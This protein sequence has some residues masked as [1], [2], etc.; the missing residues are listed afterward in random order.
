[1]DATRELYIVIAA[2][3]ENGYSVDCID[4]WEGAQAEDIHTLDVSLNAVSQEA[5]RLFENCKFRLKKE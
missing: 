1:M 3:L 5:F 2:L 4:R